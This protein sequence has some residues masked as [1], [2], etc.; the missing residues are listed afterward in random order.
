MSYIVK[1]WI[2]LKFK[3][4]CAEL[5]IG[6]FFT[7]HQNLT[8]I[9]WCNILWRDIFFYLFCDVYFLSSEASLS[10]VQ[11]IEDNQSEIMDPIA[12]FDLG[13]P[14]ILDQVSTLLYILS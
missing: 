4:I 11:N 7:L 8:M 1:N 6:D 9:N 12:L 10:K 5:H 2:M 14:V 3:F 13:D